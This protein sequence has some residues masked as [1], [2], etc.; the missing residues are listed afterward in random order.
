MSNNPNMIPHILTSRFSIYLQ[1]Y[2]NVHFLKFTVC[3]FLARTALCTQSLDNNT[4]FNND[5]N[6]R[7]LLSS[8]IRL[9]TCVWTSYSS[10]CS[11][12]VQI[13]EKVT[14]TSEIR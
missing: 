3:L 2:R 7:S 1:N 11:S 6:T 13:G 4:Y 14:Y 5:F 9:E 12:L 10:F 8:V